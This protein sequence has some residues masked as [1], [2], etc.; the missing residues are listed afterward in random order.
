MT[1]PDA[2]EPG[3]T[4]PDAAG[5]DADQA[6][7]VMVVASAPMRVS[8]AGGGTDLPSYA[9]RF[10]GA[11]VGTA[12]DRRVCV[13]RYPGRFTGGLRAAFDEVE[14]VE[15][16]EDLRHRFVRASL[17]RTGNPTDLQLGCFSDAPG[18]VGLGGSG[19]LT[20]ALQA[21]LR[22][23]GRP[24]PTELAEQASAVEMVDLDRP[25]GK[26]DHYFAAL[27]GLR[28]LRIG[29]D[30]S[31]RAELLPNRPEVVRY[32]DER[33]LLFFLGGRR[34]A[35]RSLAAQAGRTDRADPATLRLLHGI[36]ELVGTCVDA[37]R[38]GRVDELGP[39]LDAH[40]A[41]KAELSGSTGG[42]AVER[43]RAIAREGGADGSKLLGA[44]GSGFLLVSCREGGQPD[45]RAAMADAG[46]P[47]LPFRSDPRGCRVRSLRPDGR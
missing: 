22:H 31:V 38:H 25:V 27:G 15:R 19:A 20:V 47:E 5:P 29:R 21:A 46:L 43:A 17:V 36:G 26:Q 10:G 18:G 33:L 4:E 12:I 34:D 16:P 42:A 28:L 30:R 39:V 2:G 13:V 40:W 3:V 7:R 11:V 6:H 45:V 1:E 23:P 41:L 8:L 9:D 24:G 32:L 35:G 14:E 37:L 44:G